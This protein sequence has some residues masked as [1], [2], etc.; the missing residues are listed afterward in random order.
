MRGDEATVPL[1]RQAFSEG[2]PLGDHTVRMLMRN[3]RLY[4]LVGGMPQAVDAYLQSNNLGVVDQVKRDIIDLYE[5]NFYK[6]SPSSAP[7][8]LFDAIPA[9]LAKKP[10]HYH[11]SSVL[12]NRSASGVLE[13]I[14]ELAASKAVLVAYHVD[15]PNVGMSAT[16]DLEK[17]KLYLG[18]TGLFVT[19]MFKDSDFTDNVI[20]EKLLSDR[21]PV[22]MGSVY[23]N[24][25][26]QQLAMNGEG[27][28]YHT[29]PKVGSNRNYEID[30]IVSCGKEIC[31]IEVKSSRYRQ[32]ASLDNFAEK[33]SSRI[34]RQYLVHT[35]DMGKDGPITCVPTCMAQ[36]I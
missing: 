16:V 19:L 17:F 23:E 1:L 13:E 25:V 5:E 6:I 8:R 21:L 34:G 24:A 2:R 26:A 32:H 27:L 18:D 35:K 22:N 7:P 4:M 9:Q 29:W 3:Y 10:S 36:F 20:C 28:F 33:Y 12:T 15:D 14:A 11:V 30:F 31:P